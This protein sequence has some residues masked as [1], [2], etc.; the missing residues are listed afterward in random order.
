MLFT[1]LWTKWFHELI[2]SSPPSR[3]FELAN[4]GYKFFSRKMLKNEYCDFYAHFGDWLI[5]WNRDFYFILLLLKTRVKNDLAN[6]S[7]RGDRVGNHESTMMRVYEFNL[8]SLRFPDFTGEYEIVRSPISR[9]W[10]ASRTNTTRD[11]S[12][13]PC[14]K[15]L[16][17]IGQGLWL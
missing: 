1:W 8:K 15:P 12:V 2:R 14:Y 13:R 16:W 7:L 4:R 6:Y 10:A 3:L 17:Y 11:V 9:F 5:T